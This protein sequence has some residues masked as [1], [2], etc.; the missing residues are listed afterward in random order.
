M[1]VR[2]YCG[3]VVEINSKHY[4]SEIQLYRKLWKIMFNVTLNDNNN[5]KNEIINYLKKNE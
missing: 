3:K 2:S 5:Q 1:F 4:N